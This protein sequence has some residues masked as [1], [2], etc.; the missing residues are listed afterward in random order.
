MLYKSQIQFINSLKTNKFRKIHQ[1]FIIEGSKIVQEA[2]ESNYSID[3]VFAVS[4]WISANQ[5]SFPEGLQIVIVKQKELERISGL[6][7]PNQTL[8]IVSMP[9]KS[10]YNYSN[11]NGLVLALDEIKDP[12]NLGTIIRTADWFGI[13]DII[14]SNNCVDVFNPK[15]IQSSMGSFLRVNLHYEELQGFFNS[16]VDVPIYGALID[17]TNIYKTKLKDNGILLVG[18]ES[19]G[20]SKNLIPFISDKISIPR[21]QKANKE[22]AESLNA[23]IA[24][25]IICAEFRRV[26]K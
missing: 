9:D 5:S 1:K 21:F 22:S 19:K 16:L 12:G 24:T 15:V 11:D 4:E 13:N 10:A 18:N 25:A 17:G 14:C 26:S 20:I 3:S 8:A 7:T 2:I 6:K 23:S